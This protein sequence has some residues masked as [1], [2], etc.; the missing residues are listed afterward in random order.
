MIGISSLAP[1]SGKR[2]TCNAP[3]IRPTVAWRSA[4]IAYFEHHQSQILDPLREPIG[5]DEMAWLVGSD[6]RTAKQPKQ[7]STSHPVNSFT[8]VG[9]CCN[10]S[11]ENRNGQQAE[12]D[13]GL[14]DTL[15]SYQQQ[16]TQ[17]QHHHAGHELE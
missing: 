2:C 12:G 16:G 15:G 3:G 14:A 8:P 13:A 7:V 9:L 17:F 5:V 1:R 6:G 10:V 4:L 11:D